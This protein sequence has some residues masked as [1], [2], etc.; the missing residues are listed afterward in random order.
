MLIKRSVLLLIVAVL[1][2]ASA[3]AQSPAESVQRMAGLFVTAYNA[4]D[5]QKIE[6]QFNVAMAAAVPGDK[7][8]GFL[9]DMHRDFGGLSS[10]GTAVFDAPRSAR[11]PL[12]FERAK[13]ELTLSLDGDGR[14]AGLRIA[15][16]APVKPPNTGRNKTSLTLPFRSEWFVFWGGDTV[17]LNYHQDAPTQRFAFD[18]L[19]VDA[20][21]K[22]HIGSGARN[23]DYYAFGQD[24]LVDADGVVTDVVT[25]VKDN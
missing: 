9:D 23:E 22:T 24:I 6:Q 10:L 15:P 3:G 8:K 17:A 1:L 16:P 20:S 21:G 25:G 13:M 7:L 2:V 18:I 12:S 14:I 4:K 19:K 5:Y 11:F